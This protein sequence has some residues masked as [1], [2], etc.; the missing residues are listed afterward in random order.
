MANGLWR[1]FL[2]M[3]AIPLIGSGIAFG[4]TLNRVDNLE[5]DMRKLQ[6]LPVA[7]E[8]LKGEIN[9]LRDLVDRL[10]YGGFSSNSSQKTSSVDYSPN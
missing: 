3:M 9:R 4:V 10:E 7:V 8:T 6:D 1:W 5:E 2:G